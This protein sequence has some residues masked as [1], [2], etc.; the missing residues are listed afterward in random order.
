MNEN[1]S[2]KDYI[3]KLQLHATFCQSLKRR[4]K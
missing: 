3:Y 4:S 2:A 1:Y